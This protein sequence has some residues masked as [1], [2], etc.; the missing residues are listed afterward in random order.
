MS[1][2]TAV[3]ITKDEEANI[4]RCIEAVRNLAEEVIV[5]D[6]GS[7]DKTAAIAESL[8][9]RVFCR[10]WTGYGPAKQDGI[11][12]AS[13]DWILALDAD[14]VVTSSLK[15]EIIK[16]LQKKHE[17]AGYYIRRKTMFL[18]RWINYCGWYPDY[19]L[20][21]F[22]KSKG[23]FNGAFVHEKVR[24]EGPAGRLKSDLLHYS[25]KNLN[26]YFEKFN[27]Y[28][29]LGA[30]EAL[31]RNKRAGWYDIIF[32]PPASFF[33]HYI[34][35]LGFLD[36]VEGFLISFLSSMAVLTKYAKLRDMNRRRAGGRE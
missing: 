3:I 30:Q 13:Y 7:T 17:Y 19:V 32:R 12:R 34:V 21:L 24:L 9:A 4:A 27:K 25:Y 6:S 22:R 35:K 14:E 8:G 29:T 20:R 2:I 10:D 16:T 5:I 15:D 28:T 11:D 33:K 36:G 18:G 26:Q 23:S 1:A 31:D